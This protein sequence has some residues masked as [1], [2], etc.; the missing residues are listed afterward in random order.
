LSLIRRTDSTLEPSA[1]GMAL[2]AVL[3]LAVGLVSGAG[4]VVFRG[5]IALVH[6]LLFFGQLSFLYNANVHTPQSPWG[7]GVILVPMLGAI[8]VAYLVKNFAPEARGHGVPEVMEA[9]YYERARIRPVVAAIKALASGI[10][11]GSGGSVGREGPIAQIGSAFGSTL[12]QVIRMPAH[13]RATLVAAGAGAGIAATFNTPLGGV[14]FAVELLLPTTSAAT[15]LPVAI[16]CVTATY[17]SRLILGLE[18]AFSV[19]ALFMDQAHLLN[20]AAFLLFV[21]LGILLGLMAALFIRSIYWFEDRFE[22]MK[23]N[24]YTQHLMGMSLVGVTMYLLMK[25]SG[26][27]YVQGVGY[28]AIED[29]LKGALAAP[30]F[31]LLLVA[32]KLWVTSLTLGSGASGGIFSP[33][34]FMGATLGGC[35][36]LVVTGVLPDLGIGAPAFAIVGMA[37]M[38]AGATGAVITSITMLY[39]M[40]R[41]YNVILPVILTVGFAYGVRKR[42]CEASIYTA[43]ALRRG[44][45]VP[46]GLEAALDSARTAGSLM[47]DSFVVV[48][49]ASGLDQP[50]S[51]LDLG[52]QVVVLEEKGQVA[53]VSASPPSDRA[54]VEPGEA[55]YI[56]VVEQAS[57]RRVLADLLESRAD[58]ALVM[59]A[60][61]SEAT[62]DILGVI[63]TAQL[64]A[65]VRT[66]SG[67]I[68]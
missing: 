26:H 15:V 13:Q 7:A 29:I 57:M 45:F 27:Y 25:F 3:A 37:G 10:S 54:S 17:L 64:G 6:N 61:G 59:R 46:E 24:Y 58:V 34:L 42:I 9:V 50:G 20:P 48:P 68:A 51:A 53:G 55:A 5:V 33:S 40:T 31:L 43:K 47:T 30:A 56:F 19:P 8:G 41:D 4:A 12:G 22:A 2:M 1:L 36:G 21:G 60:R 44:R 62:S 38:V 67:I 28:A 39:E 49:A 52:H 11:I 35:F 23:G 65:V 14:A 18:P 63:T 32:L 16:A 66:D